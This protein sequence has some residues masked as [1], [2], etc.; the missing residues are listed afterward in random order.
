MQ[1]LQQYVED[2]HGRQSDH[3]W[4]LNEVKSVEH[5]N[6]IEHALEIEEYLEGQHQILNKPVEEYKG[7]WYEPKKVILQ[8]GKTICN[9][10]TSYLL[11]NKYQFTG[12]DR[13]K[14]IYEGVDSRGSFYQTT[15]ELGDSMSQHDYAFEYGYMD[16]NRNI[17][18]R[19]IK[20]IHSYP[21]FNDFG[22]MIAFIEHWKNARKSYYIFYDGEFVYT[23]IGGSKGGKL[24]HMDTKYSITGLPTFIST[25]QDVSKLGRSMVNDFV[26]IIDV[27]EE[28]TSK[29]ADTFHK[30]HDPIK[31]IA[32]DMV[33][34]KKKINEDIVGKVLHVSDE[35]KVYNLTTTLDYSSLKAIYEILTKALL[36]VTNTPSI[37]MNQG[38]GAANLAEVSIKMMYTLADMKAGRSEMNMRKA[39]YERFDKQRR[40]LAMKGITFT[41]EEFDSLDVQ[42]RHARPQNEKEIIDN[43]ATLK[44][45]GGISLE[46][47]LERSPLTED[48]KVELIRLE[49]EG[50]FDKPRQVVEQVEVRKLGDGNVEGNGVEIV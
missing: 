27:M 24:Q 45:V 38:G 17:K 43:I 26:P 22:T 4:L 39:F 18:S 47:I 3:N 32:G 50:Q 6:R 23:F 9:Y 10:H 15:Y 5:T 34:S 28:I 30:T 21:I 8:H 25:G 31:V 42:F 29:F 20:A 1:N 44:S 49:R 35:T 33:F 37:S 36:D 13:V 46:T 19:R 40:M 16:E 2:R 12:W 11:Q 41:D 48:V 7:E 14:E